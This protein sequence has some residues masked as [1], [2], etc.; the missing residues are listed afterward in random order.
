MFPGFDRTSQENPRGAPNMRPRERQSDLTC[1]SPGAI[2]ARRLIEAAQRGGQHSLDELVRRYEPLVRRGVWKLKPP[3]HCDR[4]DLAQEA[5]LGLLAAIRAWRPERGPFPAFADRCVSN[6]A[7]LALIAACRQKQQ[8]LN[9][10]ISLDTKHRPNDRPL[11]TLH[12]QLIG[13]NGL[14]DRVSNN[15]P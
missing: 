4:D 12:D 15:S 7:L 13:Q 6:G 3:P 11:I 9:H 10:V 1:I 2:A 5:R 14:P 8:I